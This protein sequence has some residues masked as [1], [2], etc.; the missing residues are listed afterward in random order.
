[1]GSPPPSAAP[2]IVIIGPSGS[3]KSTLGA[4]L[5]ARLQCPFIEGDHH[6]PPENLAKMIA[7]RPLTDDDRKPFLDSVANALAA[8]PRPAVASCSA[9]RRIYRDRLRSRSGDI[10]FVWIDIAPRELA[11]RLATRDGHFMPPSL[12]SDQVSA[13]EP[14][15]SGEPFVTVDGRA[16]VEEQV[17]AVLRALGA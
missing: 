6:H 2:A 10:V 15:Q 8:S 4:A 16:S 17:E 9:L 11:R 12:L 5:A 3:G 1:M 7:G 14:P 13:F